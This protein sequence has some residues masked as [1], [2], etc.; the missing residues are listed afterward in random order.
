MQ[1]YL[2][3]NGDS[4]L[5]RFER[6]E[7]SLILHHTYST[8]NAEAKRSVVPLLDQRHILTKA[9]LTEDGRVIQPLLVSKLKIEYSVLNPVKLNR[10]L[11]DSKYFCCN[12]LN[13]STR[14][15]KTPNKPNRNPLTKGSEISTDFG[16]NL[17]NSVDLKV[18]CSN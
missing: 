13:N 7:I 12:F 18:K 8:L 3:L 2:G 17:F 10:K 15:K 14:E 1:N 9:D 5:S 6:G 16:T 11:F 4:T